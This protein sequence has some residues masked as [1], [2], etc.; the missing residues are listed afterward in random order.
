MAARTCL[1]TV[2]DMRGI[3]HV[4]EVTADTLFEAAVL[5]L[6]A[7]KSDEWNGEIG[8]STRLEI[9]VQAPATTHVLSVQQIERWLDGGAKS[10]NEQVRKRKLK[11]MLSNGR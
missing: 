9:R 5:G 3:K 1:V 6:A 2:T 8:P 4:A 11:E 10:P 7:L